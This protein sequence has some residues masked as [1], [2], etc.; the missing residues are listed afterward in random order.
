MVGLPSTLEQRTFFSPWETLRHRSLPH[1]GF[2]ISTTASCVES[3]LYQVELRVLQQAVMTLLHVYLDLIYLPT[4]LLST[5][6]KKWESDFLRKWHAV[7]VWGF[8]CVEKWGGENNTKT[9][10]SVRR[11]RADQLVRG[12]NIRRKEGREGGR[13]WLMASLHQEV[14]DHVAEE[15]HQQPDGGA[16]WGEKSSQLDSWQ[17]SSACSRSAP[18][19][20]FKLKSDLSDKTMF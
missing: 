13:V 1:H 19:I 12:W 18:F 6:F 17:R 4:T 7:K 15:R 16:H 3:L 11:G 2:L 9:I 20:D 10:Q 14:A 8:V 5:G